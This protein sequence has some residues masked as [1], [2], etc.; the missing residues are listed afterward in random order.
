[1]RRFPLAIVLM[2]WCCAQAPA[3]TPD[4]DALCSSND[5][6]VSIPACTTIIQ[7]GKEPPALIPFAYTNRGLG[8]LRK[9]QN[10]GAITDFDQAIRLFPWGT[11][12]LGRGIAYT[13]KGLYKQAIADFDEA[14]RLSPG[15]NSAIAFY[16]RG[17]AK[18]SGGDAAGADADFARAKQLD[19]SIGN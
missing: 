5:P 14:I 9:G 15:K 16:N 17:L 11:A 1:M 19:P 2:V 12:Y 18:R 6:D 4:P 7:S 8:Y 13:S 10:D 3:Q